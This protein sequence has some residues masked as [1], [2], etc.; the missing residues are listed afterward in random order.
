[1]SWKVLG[2]CGSLGRQSSN[3]KLLETAV[4]VAPDS[5]ELALFNGLRDLPI[6]DP[7]TVAISPLP[8]KV[9]LWKRA[10][11]DCDAVLISSPE[12]G[13]SVPGGLKNGLDWVFHSG[14]FQKKIVV[15]TA[16]VVRP[17]QGR[18]GLA[19]LRQ[20]LEAADAR[21]MSDSTILQDEQYEE[22]IAELLDVLVEVLAFYG[23][24]K[25]RNGIF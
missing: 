19:A 13:G 20:T 16:S 23:E 25:G 5:I 10:L 4:S 17:E 7:D 14:E 1:M 9:Q 18:R 21:V 2:I 11:A 3:L 22:N 15:I 24:G 6:F 8:Q 12:Y